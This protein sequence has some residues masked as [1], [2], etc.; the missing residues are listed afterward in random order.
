MKIFLQTLLTNVETRETF[1]IVENANTGVHMKYGTFITRGSMAKG[2]WI[3][4]TCT[5]NDWG[6]K[7]APDGS[8]F[9]T[10]AEAFE[11]AKACHNFKIGQGS[12]LD[13]II[14]TYEARV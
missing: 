12:A 6:V 10:R 11:F 14:R 8:N 7:N 3:E 13:R 2:Y 1:A 4:D 5:F 9:K